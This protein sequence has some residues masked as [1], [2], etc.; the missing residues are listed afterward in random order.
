MPKV[1]NILICDMPVR[2]D[3]YKGCSHGCEY[4][5]VKLK[6]DISK[7]ET[8][9]GTQALLNFINKRRKR[10]T[11]EKIFDFDIPLHW[12]GV[13][14]PFQPLELQRRLSYECLK[15]FA[16]TKYPFVI[17]TK[18]S[19]IAR[20][21][22]LELLKQFNCAVQFSAVGSSYDTFEAGATP[23][24]ERV[25]AMKKISDLGIRVIVRAQPFIPKVERE[26][27]KNLDLFISAG[28]YGIIIEFMKYKSKKPGTIKVRGD[29]VFP[30]ETI[31]PVFDRIKEAAN[32]KGL[33]V[34]AGENRLRQY[35]D[36]LNCCGVGDLWP[37]HEANLN[38][39]LWGENIV[40]KKVYND[41]IN[42]AAHSFVTGIQNTKAYIF[43]KQSTYCELLNIGMESKI[44][45]SNYTIDKQAYERIKNFKPFETAQ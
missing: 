12:G 11:V 42:E 5:F 35:G 28:V 15:I 8:D 3:T 26:F 30:L 43:T 1:S 22:Y 27:I 18:N 24:T 6:T 9:E 33:K 36:G 34:F 31:K 17:S 37:C 4:C 2:F 29:M 14:D 39:L 38:H 25:E 44:T 45:L 10:E 20:P 13:S 40:F 19:I 7:I 16:A 21:E 32:K 41:K 23:F